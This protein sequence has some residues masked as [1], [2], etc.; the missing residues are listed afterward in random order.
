MAVLSYPGVY[1]DEVPSG[2][3]TITGVATSITAF[4][5]RAL[6]GPVDKAVTITSY[7]DFERIYGGL[8]TESLL[9][10]A[11]NDFYS[12]GGAIAVIVRVYAPVTT[13][14]PVGTDPGIATAN[15]GS[16]TKLLALRAASPGAWGTQLEATLDVDV[17]TTS[18]A[19][20]NLAIRDKA[21]GRSE[22]FRRVSHATAAAR[23]VD[24]VLASESSLASVVTLPTAAPDAAVGPAAFTGGG[25]GVAISDAVI[26][27]GTGLAD[28]KL[29]LFALEDV[30]LV[31]MIVI[32]PYGPTSLGPAVT[33]G[34]IAYAKKRRAIV[35]M[36]PPEATLLGAAG[37]A[38]ASALA[39]L[40]TSNYAAVYF[41]RIRKP[42]PLRDGQLA[43]FR[44]RGRR[45]RR[46][47]PHRRDARRLEGAGRASTRRSTALPSSRSRSPTSRSAS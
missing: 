45:R 41:P 29:G 1:I 37:S 5:G 44:T 27:G 17:G 20:F 28:A 30:D 32:P 22:L 42:D 25:D 39:A 34:A 16:S 10:Y 15:L 6:R 38:G 33:T 7:A 24:L 12:Q 46:H 43:T 8:W 4:I 21:T 19:V 47:R 26:S 31:N 23:R 2:V 13:T 3:R 14:N 35:I 18:D 40:P 11:V 36:D 9:G